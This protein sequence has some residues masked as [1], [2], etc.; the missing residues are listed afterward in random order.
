M[1]DPGKHLGVVIVTT[2]IHHIIATI[3][4]HNLPTGYGSRVV[5]HQFWNPAFV[6]DRDIFTKATGASVKTWW[7]GETASRGT[8]RPP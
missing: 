1:T 8:G 3:R 2:T 4:H 7:S 5:R 6:C